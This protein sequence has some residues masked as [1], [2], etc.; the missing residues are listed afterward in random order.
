MFQH[1]VVCYVPAQ[2]SV[3]LTDSGILPAGLTND[4]SGVVSPKC[5]GDGK[6]FDFRRTT[7]FVFGTPLRKA[8]ND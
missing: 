5:L 1:K 8:Q 6:M 2:S 3:L 7:I 4:S